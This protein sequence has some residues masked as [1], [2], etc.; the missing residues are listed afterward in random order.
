MESPRRN[1]IRSHGD[2]R[3]RVTRSGSPGPEPG[4]RSPSGWGGGLLNGTPYG[5]SGL[6]RKDCA[7]RS[8]CLERA[9]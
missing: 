4:A 6:I 8:I 2:S 5:V 7:T 1:L 3:L 9:L